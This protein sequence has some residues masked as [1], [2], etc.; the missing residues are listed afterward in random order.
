MVSVTGSRQAAALV[1][2]FIV[3]A[4]VF[5][6]DTVIKVI[7]AQG[8]VASLVSIVLLAGWLVTAVFGFHDPIHTRHPVRGALGLF[9]VASLLSFAAMP[10]YGPNETQRLSAARWIMLL[11]GMSGVILVTAELVK[12]PRDLLRVVRTLVWGAAFSGAVA[13]AQYTVAFDLKPYLRMALPGFQ[14]DFAYSG[15]QAREALTRVSGTANHPI[16][17]G[18]IAGMLLPT[19]IWLGFHERGRSPVRRWAPVVLIGACV[20]MSVS[21]SAVLAII[22]AT[23][24]FVAL[25][26][27]VERAW[28]LGFVPVALIAVFATTPGY[29]RTITSSFDGAAT[30][31]SIAN[32]INNYP[33]VLAAFRAA[34]WFGRG[35]GTDI[36]PDATKILDNQYLKS[37]IELGGF[38][39]LALVL[40]FGVPALAALG[41]RR[42]TADQRT[43]SL[44]AAVAGGCLASLVG[45]YTFDALS[46]SQFASVEAVMVGLAGACWLGVRR[47]RSGWPEVGC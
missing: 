39:L 26:P 28:L 8:Y 34:P 27:V 23:V 15:F 11:A 21:R 44:C 31:P 5:P 6:T 10:F 17:L 2:V 20:P 40:F 35:G 4:F 36:A 14:C 25:L 29:F 22:V 45:G 24:L 32:R 13:V 18:V 42:A 43:R 12:T 3:T 37:A 7:G 46:F 38:G 41:A 33:R 1:Q 47:W 30:D 9:W 16:E 19:A